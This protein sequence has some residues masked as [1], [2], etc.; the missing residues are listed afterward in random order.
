MKRRVNQTKRRTDFSRWSFCIFDWMRVFGCDEAAAVAINC[1]FDVHK[2]TFVTEVDRVSARKIS[3][4]LF[5]GTICASILC[6]ASWK[7]NFSI[8]AATFSHFIR[9]TWNS[10]CEQ[11][12][13]TNDVRETNL[14]LM[15]FRH[16]GIRKSFS[17]ARR[18]RRLCVW[19]RISLATVLTETLHSLWRVKFSIGQCRHTGIDDYVA[20]G[21]IRPETFSTFLL[22]KFRCFSELSQCFLSNGSELNRTFL[23]ATMWIT[24]RKRHKW[25]FSPNKSF[26]LNFQRK[27]PYFILKCNFW[28]SDWMWSVTFAYALNSERTHGAPDHSWS[29]FTASFHS[30]ASTPFPP[31]FCQPLIQ[32]TFVRN[33]RF[34]P[35]TTQRKKGK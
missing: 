22:A 12:R 7:I 15:F 29:E 6:I 30:Q 28:A 34:S 3:T 19:L 14:Q 24:R 33:F 2:H 17:V 32:F 13:T 1:H 20:T 4:Q 23:L 27:F 25:M 26:H 16:G 5:G 9:F 10:Q 8:R 18:M 21:T 11:L 35:A 31:I